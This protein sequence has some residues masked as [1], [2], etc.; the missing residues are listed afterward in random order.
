[1]KEKKTN[2]LNIRIKPVIKRKLRD[3]AKKEKTTMSTAAN[4][5]LEDYFRE[6]KQ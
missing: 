5:I 4:H 1:M 6:S 2:T 3:K